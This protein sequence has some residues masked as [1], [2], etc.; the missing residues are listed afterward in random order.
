M[1]QSLN[2][3]VQPSLHFIDLVD[4]FAPLADVV[5]V[6]V[7]MVEDVRVF[8]M[9]MVRYFVAHLAMDLVVGKMVSASR[10]DRIAPFTVVASLSDVEFRVAGSLC[11]DD[12]NGKL[13]L[14]AFGIQRE[15]V[16]H[17]LSG[18]TLN[19]LNRIRC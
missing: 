5:T 11:D 6:F 4:R 19:G 1:N 3:F 18:R 2:L 14:E 13:S 10:D 7:E 16:C 17:S 12:V 8:P 15:F 9:F